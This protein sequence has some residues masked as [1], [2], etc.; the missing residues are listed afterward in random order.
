L[1]DGVTA[2]ARVRESRVTNGY[3]TLNEELGLPARP[4]TPSMFVPLLT[5]DLGCPDAIRQWA[6]TLAEDWERAGVRTG[7]HSAGFAAA[8][9][10]RAG[11]EEGRWLM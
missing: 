8:C 11:R 5:S 4:V 1:L 7:V 3:K 2:A 10:Y 6:P 9:R